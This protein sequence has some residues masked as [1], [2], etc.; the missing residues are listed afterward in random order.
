[1]ANDKF[2]F[3][4]LDASFVSRL[5]QVDGSCELL[6]FFSL[7]ENDANCVI[8]S[9][10]YFQ[11]PCNHFDSNCSDLDD[12][13]SDEAAVNTFRKGKIKIDLSRIIKDPADV[14]AFLWAHDT[15]DA[16]IWT[17]DKNLLALCRDYEIPRYCFKAAL[18]KLDNYLDG[19]IK[20]EANYT[21]QKMDDG[22]DPFFN[23]NK[24]SRCDSHCGLSHSCVCF[25]PKT[26][27]IN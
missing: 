24:N 10:Q 20:K 13:F 7:S 11:S 6:E 22:D 8:K 19:A 9:D 27:E 12:L 14:K 15:Q 23:Y 16:A 26:S 2:S 17:C 4:Y 5:Q 3:L 18:L 25:E 21:I 1:M